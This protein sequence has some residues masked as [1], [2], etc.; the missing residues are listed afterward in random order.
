MPLDTG[1]S[2]GLSSKGYASKSRFKSLSR[3][4][5]IFKNEGKGQM[6]RERSIDNKHL[7]K[8][9]SQSIQLQASQSIEMRQSLAQSA[10][11]LYLR[12]WAADRLANTVNTG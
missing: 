12:G 2:I 10:E 6:I 1:Y 7:L 3:A 11:K 8:R 9:R 5:T 4:G